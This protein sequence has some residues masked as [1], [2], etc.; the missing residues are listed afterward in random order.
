[1][2]IFFENGR[3]GNQLIQYCGLKLLFPA[4]RL[5]FFGCVD[6]Q[7]HFDGVEA[8]FLNRST[9]N[10]YIPAFILEYIFYFLAK[11]RVLGQISED[12]RSDFFKLVVRRGLLWNIL[13]PKNL[14]FQHRDVLDCIKNAP[15]LK[16]H[17]VERAFWWVRSKEI[18]LESC[19]LV[20]VHLRRG[21][22]LYWPSKE[23]PAVLDLSWYRGAM[24]LMREKI[25]SPVFVLMG[26]DQYYLR[27][28]FEE[29]DSLFISNNSPEVDLALMSICQSGIL[30]ASSFSWWGALCS[31]RNGGRN[32]KFIAPNYWA[33]FRSKKW[34]PSGFCT[35]WITYL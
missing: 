24:A 3:L 13:V 17:L 28:I 27:D 26:D 4:E 5:I 33:G 32:A 23:F 31:R 34:Y 10:R 8:R 30:S 7:Q 19:S 20:F 14:F 15:V 18:D 6:L 25:D 16:P 1:M 11:I 22:Y 29:S 2:I 12:H 21:D 35:D 9:I